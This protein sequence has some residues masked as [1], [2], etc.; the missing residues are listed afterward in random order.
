MGNPEVGQVHRVSS[1]CMVCLFRYCAGLSLVSPAQIRNAAK[2]IP[3][4]V[5]SASSSAL[6]SADFL[7]Y[8]MALNKADCEKSGYPHY[9]DRVIFYV[10]KPE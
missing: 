5:N 4:A 10:D 6:S 7:T 9:W 2:L 1:R 3:P 8:L